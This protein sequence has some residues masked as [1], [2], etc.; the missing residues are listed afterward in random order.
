MHHIEL[1]KHI[2]EI[3]DIE[4]YTLK[5]T[6][7]SAESKKLMPIGD[8]DIAWFN[9]IYDKLPLS[10]ENP[11]HIIELFQVELIGIIELFEQWISNFQQ[12]QANEKYQVQVE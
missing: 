9:K 2:I 12:K 3:D 7:D 11:P 8:N 6:L 1:Q 5:Q 4:L 10:Q